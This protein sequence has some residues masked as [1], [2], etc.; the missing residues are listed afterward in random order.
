MTVE[1]FLLWQ[2]DQPNLHELVDGRPVRQPDAKQAMRREG[3]AT[4]AAKVAN[5]GELAAGRRWLARPHDELG[6][7]PRDVAAEC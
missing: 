4:L 6:A 7:V 3:W 5:G 1:E 2:R